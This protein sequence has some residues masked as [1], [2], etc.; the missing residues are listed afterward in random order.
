MV[1][2]ARDAISKGT[3]LEKFK[4]DQLWKKPAS[5]TEADITEKATFAYR[6][7]ELELRR[8][9]LI[10]EE[11]EKEEEIFKTAWESVKLG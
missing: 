11:R 9:Q 7:S 1:K 2:E 10:L 6:T 8:E 4:T 5:S 3:S